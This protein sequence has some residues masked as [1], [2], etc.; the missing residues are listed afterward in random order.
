MVCLSRIAHQ[1]PWRG[2]C[3]NSHERTRRWLGWVAGNV[4]SKNAVLK[5]QEGTSQYLPP[6]E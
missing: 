3:D 5:V 2:M 6:D 4:K 1:R